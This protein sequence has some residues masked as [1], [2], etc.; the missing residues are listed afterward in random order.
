MIPKIGDSRD[1]WCDVLS[2]RLGSH[3]WPK[4]VINGSGDRG[5]GLFG[6]SSGASLEFLEMS[7]KRASQPAE[8][9]VSHQ[10]PPRVCQGTRN[11]RQIDTAVL[12]RALVTE[13]PQRLEVAL[14]RHQ[15]EPALEGVA[16]L[17][18]HRALAE[19]LR[20]VGHEVLVQVD[21]AVAQQRGQ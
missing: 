12:H 16:R 9:G 5:C 19:L 3:A 8:L 10:V 6:L 11:V 21:V 7:R 4:G 15:L 2:W 18:G 14:D 17:A 1:T 20:A 13:R